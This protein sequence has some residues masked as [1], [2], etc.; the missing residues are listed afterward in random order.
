VLNHILSSY[1]AT[2]ASSLPKPGATGQPEDLKLLK[3]SI[4]MLNES[5]EKLG[6]EA[7]QFKPGKIT[8]TPKKQNEE[9][10]KDGI[11]LREQLGFINKISVDIGRVTGDILA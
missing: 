8:E 3:R 11:L 1:I 9:A 6:G 5:T 4:A 10:G 7:L 2:V